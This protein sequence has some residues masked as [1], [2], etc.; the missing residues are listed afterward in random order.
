VTTSSYTRRRARVYLLCAAFCLLGHPVLAVGLPDGVVI[1]RAYGLT[2]TEKTLDGLPPWKTDVLSEEKR[3]PGSRNDRVVY[4]SRNSDPNADL[5]LFT[6]VCVWFED[7]VRNS[8]TDLG[9]VE[10]RWERPQGSPMPANG[11]FDAAIDVTR[12]QYVKLGGPSAFNAERNWFGYAIYPAVK[13]F[14][15]TRTFPANSPSPI[16]GKWNVNSIARAAESHNYLKDLNAEFH[17]DLAKFIET[18][19]HMAPGASTM[20]AASKYSF[21]STEFYAA[22]GVDASLILLPIGRAGK[23]GKLVYGTLMAGTV[24]I[25]AY[26]FT[27]A[28]TDQEKL[29]AVL[30]IVMCLSFAHNV[31][32]AAKPKLGLRPPDNLPERALFDD[33]IGAAPTK[34]AIPVGCRILG[35][36]PH[37]LSVAGEFPTP[38]LFMKNGAAALPADLRA[39]VQGSARYKRLLSIMEKNPKFFHWK[40]D[41]PG[42]VKA[43]IGA[44]GHIYVRSTNRWARAFVDIWHEVAHTEIYQ[45]PF[46]TNKAKFTATYGMSLKE[47]IAANRH[48]L[49]EEA[50]VWADCAMLVEELE[51]HGASFITAGGADMAAGERAAL[52]AITEG[53]P[54]T[55]SWQGLKE[56]LWDEAGYDQDI[57]RTLTSI[58]NN[59]GGVGGIDLL[60]GSPWQRR[61]GKPP[62]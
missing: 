1:S 27:K 40:D 31:T 49:D 7:W 15:Y 5:M 34:R 21:Y 26:N 8:R 9:I 61:L 25:S 18:I 36:V 12:D 39:Y 46:V 38:Y 62:F 57:E 59:N 37:E 33:L 19:G 29:K 51:G 3:Q 48:L 13:A 2:I 54:V 41:L 4:S 42:L 10:G 55:R 23:A 52:K 43:E 47:F 50:F 22:A 45:I 16:W 11:C 35:P 44:D 32:R 60:D 53:A 14:V 28:E 17:F 20:E 24:G 56:F 30:D 58:Y 6:P